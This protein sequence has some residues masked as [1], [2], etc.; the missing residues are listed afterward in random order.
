MNYDAHLKF[1]NSLINTVVKGVYNVELEEEVSQYLT[2]IL[3]SLP[4]PADYDLFIN[5]YLSETQR[6]KSGI[7]LIALSVKRELNE[8]DGERIRLK[9]DLM[10]KALDDFRDRG[11][12]KPTKE[13]I[14]NWILNQDE[15]NVL[16]T[17]YVEY[18]KFINFLDDVRG[19]L[20]SRENI[21]KEISINLRQDKRS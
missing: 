10:P 16:Y 15:Y 20:D 5:E 2:E 8:I 1:F 17:R 7:I 13:Q 6:M 21:L 9:T 18:E 3:T 12:R 4:I 14:N 19:L 11:V